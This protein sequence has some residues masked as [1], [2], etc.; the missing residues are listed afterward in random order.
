MDVQGLAGR[1]GVKLVFRVD[2]SRAMGSGHLMRCLTLAQALRSRGANCRFIC[3]AHP[4]HLIALVQAQGF[5]V[6]TLPA[7]DV[8]A[9]SASTSGRAQYDAW[10][11]EPAARDAQQTIE[12]LSAGASDTSDLSDMPDWLV[13]DHYAIDAGWES[14]VRPHVRRIM[15]I[16]D[17]AD[18]VHDC[19]LLLD[20][21]F[22]RDMA[23]RY[24]GLV[25]AHARLLLGP[26][27]VLLRPEFIQARQ[28]LRHRDG[29]VR[30]I[31]VF[32]GGSDVTHQTKKALQAMQALDSIEAGGIAVDAVIG[33]ATPEPYRAELQALVDALPGARLHCQVSNMAEL[34]TQADLGIGAGGAAMWERCYLGLPTLTVTFADNQVRTTEAAAS[35][36]A[37]TY[38]GR[39]N[40]SDAPAFTASDYQRAIA[41]ALAAP[42]ALQ[43]QSATALAL[44]SPGAQQVAEL[45]LGFTLGGQDLAAANDT[46]A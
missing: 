6:V 25:P 45:M 14:M 9:T 46:Q 12:H 4:G 27:Q 41:A 42:Q 13:V 5:E 10:L 19:E 30:R 15:V 31:L 11:G 21:N 7:A 3:R 16:D 35:L 18:R 20:Q 33:A 36:G 2:A 1:C 23:S 22:Y 29:Q 38:L 37:I 44:V 39:C 8:P 24:D 34:I 40:A 32:F 28:Q 26:G 17:L 43:H